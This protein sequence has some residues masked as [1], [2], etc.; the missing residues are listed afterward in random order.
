MEALPKS[1][2]RQLLSLLRRGQRA[3][4]EPLRITHHRLATRS[5]I[6]AYM[7]STASPRLILGSGVHRRPG[8]LAS[9]IAPTDGSAIFIDARRR[10]PFGDGT[11]SYVFAEH[12]LEHIP[13]SSGAILAREVMRVLRPGGVFRVATPD[14]A[15]VGRLVAGPRDAAAEA[16][17]DASSKLYGVTGAKRASFAVNRFFYWWGHRFIYDQPTLEE[18]LRQAGF[19]QID[20][21]RPGQSADSQL[22]DLEIHGVGVGQIMNEYETM[23]LEARKPGLG[24][25]S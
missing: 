8:W 23:V 13:Y 24:D 6:A 12:M 4:S 11:L 21:C 3:L 20:R 9:D 7:A 19:A 22:C 14:L 2:T 10:L 16:F 18:V 1:P 5:R 15:A 17:I 25:G